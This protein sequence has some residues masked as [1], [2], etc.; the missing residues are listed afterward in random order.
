MENAKVEGVVR[1]H[2]HD[3]AVDVGL[4]NAPANPGTPVLATEK[5]R[6]EG[7]ARELAER[8]DELVSRIQRWQIG[9]EEG[10][11]PAAAADVGT[12]RVAGGGG[13]GLGGV[14]LRQH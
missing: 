14:V 2:H 9:T 3:A 7:S 5:R 12:G 10:G 1:D 8:C 11:G 13:G 6:G 4:Y